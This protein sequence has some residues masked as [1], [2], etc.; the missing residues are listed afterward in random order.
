MTK[1]EREEKRRQRLIE[2]SEY[3]SGLR[4]QGYHY[5][6]GMDEVG[7]GPL[8]GPVYAS[9]VVLPEAFDGT[10]IDDSKKLTERRR[11]DLSRRIR[12]DA[13]AVGMGQASPEEIDQYNILEATRIAMKRAF[14]DANRQLEQVS[15]GL[16]IDYLLIDALTLDRMDIPQEGIVH[17]DSRILS[18]A[19]ASI[20]AKTARDAYMTEMSSQYPGYAFEKNK[21]YGT[22]QHY[23]GIRQ[24]G[25]TEIHRKTFLKNLEERH[26]ISPEK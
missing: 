9:C 11:N 14:D 20:V 16:H 6:A 22:A 13:L 3:E 2:L 7:R 5:I 25:I 15:G 26:H 24:H 21:G 4:A 17:G 18:I 10:G 8:A 1:Q 23:E 19:A 12:Q